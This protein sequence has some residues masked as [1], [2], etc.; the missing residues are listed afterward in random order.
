MFFSHFMA[1]LTRLSS[2]LTPF[3][4]V[5]IEGLRLSIDGLEMTIDETEGDLAEAK[6]TIASM[7]KDA[8]KMD[9]ENK[10]RGEEFTEMEREVETLREEMAALKNPTEE[11]ETVLTYRD[12]AKRAEESEARWAEHCRFAEQKVNEMEQELA[13]MRKRKGV[14]PGLMGCS[15]EVYQFICA[16]A[17]P[18]RS[19]Y[20]Q[21]A[22]KRVERDG[23]HAQ[24][25]KEMIDK[26]ANGK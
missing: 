23:E 21:T 12:R 1:D 22:E 11:G 19:D 9:K 6:E 10:E 18:V 3:S 17:S 24:R 4:E 20:G 5:N 8:A 25:L 13:A 26:R 14:E 2:R 16:I 15:H 7:E